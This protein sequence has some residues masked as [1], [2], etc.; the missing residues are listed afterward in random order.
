MPTLYLTHQGSQL[1]FAAGRLTV[2]LRRKE[3]FSAP[4]ELVDQVVAVGGVQ[5]TAR[6][7]AFLLDNGIETSF[8][9]LH[10]RF[11][12]RL[13]PPLSKNVALRK[14]TAAHRWQ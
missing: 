10:G 12:G 1:G 13:Q 8:L 5:I 3:L 9:T 6:A 2:R 7:L 14:A 11:R 4:A